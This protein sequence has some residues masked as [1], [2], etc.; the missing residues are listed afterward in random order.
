MPE[1]RFI[2]VQLKTQKFWWVN[3]KAQQFAEWLNQA[4]TAVKAASRAKDNEFLE[5]HG[6]NAQAAAG[7]PA[8]AS[9]S[10]VKREPKTDFSMNP[11][12]IN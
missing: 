12:L 8:A 9:E 6:K 5:G 10:H 2:M 7:A 11:Y 4:G 1:P 3:P